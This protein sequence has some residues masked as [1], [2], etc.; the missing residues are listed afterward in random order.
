[1]AAGQRPSFAPSSPGRGVEQLRHESPGPLVIAGHDDRQAGRNPTDAR[2]DGR[3]GRNLASPIAGLQFLPS[4]FDDQRADGIR[5]QPLHFAVESFALLADA[6]Q[7]VGQTF[8][9]T[10]TMVSSPATE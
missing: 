5:Q 1:M 3:R 4:R 10:A 7:Q 8:R 2:S 6:S 9:S